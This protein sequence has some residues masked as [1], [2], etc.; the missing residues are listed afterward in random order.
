MYMS[1]LFV[2]TQVCISQP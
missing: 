2:M 1:Q